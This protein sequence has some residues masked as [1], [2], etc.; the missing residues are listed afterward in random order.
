MDQQHHHS[1]QEGTIAS[2][3]PKAAEDISKYDHCTIDCI[4]TDC[5]KAW[6]GKCSVNNRKALRR[7][8][9]MAQYITGTMQLPIQ[10]I[11]SVP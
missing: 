8:V 5:V 3:L 9:K 2:L 10:D 4:L 11:Y 7:V 1:S 6:Y